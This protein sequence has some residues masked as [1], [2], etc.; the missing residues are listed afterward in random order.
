MAAA[1]AA[2]AAAAAAKK[3]PG[4][5]LLAGLFGGAKP[6]KQ[7]NTDTKV[8]A[9]ARKAE[10]SAQV[11]PPLCSIA[12]LLL[13]QQQLGAQLSLA[14]GATGACFHAVCC[15]AHHPLPSAQHST[16]GGGNTRIGK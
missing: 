3:R 7:E 5:G 10:R 1:E 13:T 8:E 16:G 14:R 4:A 6:R 2:A 12:A 11:S 9:R 15:P